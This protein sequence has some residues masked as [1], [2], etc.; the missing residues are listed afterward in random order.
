MKKLLIILLLI[1]GCEE[2]DIEGK[3]SI[4]NYQLNISNVNDK[5]FDFDVFGVSN[6]KGRGICDLEGKA[7]FKSEN[8]A[9]FTDNHPD[10]ELFGLDSCIYTFG[11][12]NDSIKISVNTNRCASFYCGTSAWLVLKYVKEYQ[13]LK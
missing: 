8:T 1:V 12:E 7:I 2:N 9:I 11:I 5:G 10:L 13:G 3:Y 4:G 6:T